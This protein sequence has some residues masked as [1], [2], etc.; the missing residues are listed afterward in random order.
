MRISDWSSDVCSSDLVGG[1]FRQHMMDAVCK[2]HRHGARTCPHRDRQS[3]TSR[4]HAARGEFPAEPRRGAEPDQLLAFGR[5]RKCAQRIAGS[6]EEHTSEL[7][8]LMPT[9]YAFFCLKKKQDTA[10]K[11]NT[12]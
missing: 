4:H 7:Q 10:K 2:S 9:W 6:S 5:H 1:G 12:Y 11:D 8:S 3:R